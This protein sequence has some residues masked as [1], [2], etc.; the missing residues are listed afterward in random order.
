V[1]LPQGFD[2]H[3]GWISGGDADSLL[4]CLY[5]ELSWQQYAIMLF[6]RKRLQPRLTAWCSDP[7]VEYRYSGI[8]LGPAPWHPALDRLRRRLEAG[9]ECP[10]NCVLANAYR[11]GQDAMGWHADDEPELGERP[12]IASVSLGQARAFRFRPRGGGPSRAMVLGHGS[13]LVMSGPSQSEWQHAI[14]RSRKPLGLRVNLT[15]RR[16]RSS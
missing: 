2:Y 12:T 6:G 11:D 7:G 13:L 9:L 4:R 14:P 15:F 3:P 5:E 16:I 8:C 10:F 1:S